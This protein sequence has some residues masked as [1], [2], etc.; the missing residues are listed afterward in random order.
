MTRGGSRWPAFL[1][2]QAK[3]HV[4][5]H[6]HVREQ[7]IALKDGIDVA[8]FGRNTGYVTVLKM[9]VAIIDA[10]Q[11]GDKAQYGCLAAAG[12]AKQRKKLAVIDGQIEVGNDL[13]AIKTFTNSFK[14]HQ[15]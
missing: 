4:L 8:I 3:R 1:H 15:R 13:F 5:K 14:L 9:D 7:G 2:P 11:P 10:F 6:G 12:G